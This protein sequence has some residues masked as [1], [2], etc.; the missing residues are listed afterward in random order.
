[1]QLLLLVVIRNARLFILTISAR[2][3]IHRWLLFSL[4]GFVRFF[5]RRERNIVLLTSFPRANW[6]ELNKISSAFEFVFL[7]SPFSWNNFNLENV[8]RLFFIFVVPE[9]RKKLVSWNRAFDDTR[10]LNYTVFF[11]PRISHFTKG[12]VHISSR[13]TSRLPRFLPREK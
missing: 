8:E 4:S 7:L 10:N 11:S 6:D 13:A 9:R 1:M 5:R 2:F 12:F 3:W